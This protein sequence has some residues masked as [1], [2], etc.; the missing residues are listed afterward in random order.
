MVD[1][2]AK[3][4]QARQLAMSGRADQARQGLLRALQ[5]HPGHP[6]LS[7]ALALV[8]GMLGQHELAA[9]HAQRAAAGRP[10]D[11]GV[12]TNLANALA[13]AGKTDQALA[14]FERAIA[15]DPRSPAPRLG[16]SHVLRA[17]LRFTAAAE[18][19]RVGLE[20]APSDHELLVARA[21]LLLKVAR[22]EDAA[23][24][25]RRATL[26]AP[27]DLSAA[28]ALAH[29]SNYDPAAT[30]PGIAEAHRAFGRILEASAPPLPP[31]A[32]RVMDPDRPI[33]VGLLSYDLRAHPVGLFI[34]PFFARRDRARVSLACYYTAPAE[35][36]V[37]ARLRSLADMWRP[38][39]ALPDAAIAAQMR[40]DQVDL[41][42]DLSGLTPNHRLGVMAL[43]PAPAQATFL[44]YPSTTGLSRIDAR[45]V[46]RT[47]DPH[48]HAVER[49]VRL[50]PPFLCYS[51]PPDAPEP[52][53][54]P[55]LARGHVTFGSFNSAPK[56]N[57]GVVASWAE[58]LRRTPGSRLLVKALEFA[59]PGLRD[60]FPRRFA[61]L[62][63]DP[64]RVEV[65]SQ[66]PSPRDHLALYQRADVAL[67]TFPYN[68]TTTTCEALWM[69]VPVV[70]LAGHTHAGRVSASLLPAAGE[71]TL[72][73]D[74]AA[75]VDLACALAADVPRLASER[76]ARRDRVR[77][78][79][80]C[81]AE[82]WVRRFE[83]ALRE[84]WRDRCARGTGVAR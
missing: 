57:R 21:L 50:D 74:A 64:A 4:E 12:A 22:V 73:P 68:G 83:A 15:L 14:A 37:A 42:I 53:P 39:A 46:D 24:A 28:A 1:V 45:I 11:P 38:V 18:H 54:T 71:P 80:L 40:A 27:A 20:A 61:T 81:D 2:S 16:I 19:L 79:A 29:I 10:N 70:A 3:L 75:Y 32:T 51:G 67:D 33:R 34:E 52:S 26:A 78:S 35:D 31:D 48:D 60:E 58:V 62:G 8:L 72:A 43:A 77:A 76:A 56:I 66:T 49:L 17:A 25:A 7:N 63:V 47:T 65:L 23:D 44:G 69:G 59:D 36:A 41:L 82:G 9:F 30:G 6:D 55:A 5:Q 13:Q 84:V